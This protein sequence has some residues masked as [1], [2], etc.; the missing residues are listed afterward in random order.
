MR[1]RAHECHRYNS[2]THAYTHTQPTGTNSS[3]EHSDKRE[4]VAAHTSKLVSVAASALKQSQDMEGIISKIAAL[5]TCHAQLLSGALSVDVRGGLDGP[6]GLRPGSS[7]VRLQDWES[8]WELLLPAMVFPLRVGHSLPLEG[9]R[10]DS[11]HH[12]WSQVTE[13]ADKITYTI[14]IA[15]QDRRLAHRSLAHLVLTFPAGT[16]D[17]QSACSDD[18]GLSQDN[19]E[20]IHDISFHLSVALTYVD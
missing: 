16:Q 20:L 11:P 13:T 19:W 18:N 14:A 5:A 4:F 6:D 3:S 12:P 15:A 2:R 7:Q 9:L 17:Q 1:A 10:T 8:S